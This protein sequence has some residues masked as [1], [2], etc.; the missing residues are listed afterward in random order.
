MLDNDHATPSGKAWG[1]PLWRFDVAWQALESRLCAGVLIAEIAAIALWVFLR[2][3]A[4]D[5]FPGQ[6]AAGLICRAIL[7]TAA[8]GVIAHL[9]THRDEGIG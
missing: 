7:S 3:L 4:S 2:G 1:D 8:L 5:Y 6:N 9:V